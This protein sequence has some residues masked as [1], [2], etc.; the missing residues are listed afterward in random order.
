MKSKKNNSVMNFPPFITHKNKRT[1]VKLINS[2][3]KLLFKPLLQQERF[4]EVLSWI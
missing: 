1:S 3:F 4:C 2:L